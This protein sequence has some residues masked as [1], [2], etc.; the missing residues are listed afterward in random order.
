MEAMAKQQHIYVGLSGGVDSA[1]AAAL[2]LEAG[3]QVTGITMQTWIDP[4][5]KTPDESVASSQLKAQAVADAL[6]IP[7]VTVDLQERFFQDVVQ[8]FI[9]NYTAGLTPNPCMLCNPQIKWGSLQSVALARGADFFATGHY[10]R[11][12]TSDSGGVRLLRGLDA[13]KDQ[14]YVLAML[15]Q[16]QLARTRLP[17][18][19]LHK[20][21]V[22]ANAK[23]LGLSAADEPESQD[24]CF[25]R[26]GDYRAF[27]RRYAPD[28][29]ESGEIVNLEG[30]VLGE[31]EGLPF[32]TVGQRKGLRVGASEPY[33]VIRKD[34]L[35]RR[36]VVGFSDQAEKKMLWASGVNWIDNQPP[37]VNDIFDVMTHYRS[38]PVPARLLMATESEFRLEFLKSVVGVSPGQ[39]AVLYRAEECLGGGIIQPDPE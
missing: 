27:L 5:V 24:L 10:A 37:N 8:T 6:K 12:E 3:Y 32:Y 31:H 7:L 13:N 11:I 23:K 35:K 28:L 22:L 2:C 33:Y 34:N 9:H 17:L 20:S 25:L 16:D 19:V 26:S 29:I 1:V 38:R 36:L 14:S 18:G 15:S 30:K 21:E 39:F 4:E